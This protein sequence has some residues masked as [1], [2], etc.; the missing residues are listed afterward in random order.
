MVSHVP[1][2][3][4][5]TFLTEP[6]SSSTF[7]VS[8]SITF[9]RTVVRPMESQRRRQPHYGGHQQLLQHAVSH[10]IILLAVFPQL[11]KICI[12][13][14]IRHEFVTAGWL[15]TYL[16]GGRKG[17]EDVYSIQCTAYVN[18]MSIEIYSEL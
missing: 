7:L 6:L 15:Y 9:L 8:L 12:G 3:L 5:C 17:R 14:A 13:D 1:M 16:C 2:N 4:S 10:T 11:V 18:D